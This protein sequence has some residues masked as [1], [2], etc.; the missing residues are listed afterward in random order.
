M[1]LIICEKKSLA[2][3]VAKALNCS[4]TNNNYF[5]NDEVYITW[6]FGHLFERV[7]GKGKWNITTLPIVQH[8]SD[9][10]IQYYNLKQDSGVKNQFKTI[11]MLANK[12]V[13]IINCCDPDTEGETIY[14]EV[15]ENLN[16]TKTQSR[17]W[18][19]DLTGTEL[20]NAY[21]NRQPLSNFNGIR[22]RGYGR[23]YFD[24]LYGINMTQLT[25]LIS[26]QTYHVGRV[27]TPT[28]KMIVDRYNE[29]KDFKQEIKY[30]PDL[31][32]ENTSIKLSTKDNDIFTDQDSV[33]NYLKQLG[34]LEITKS[35]V[36]KGNVKQPTLHDLG[37]IQ[38]WADTNLKISAKDT[39]EIVQKLYLNKLVSYPRTN[40]KYITQNT[41]EK[42]SK[43]LGRELIAGI[44]DVGNEHEALTPIAPYC[45]QLEGNEKAI[46]DEI[47]YTT[48]ANT[49]QPIKIDKL[50]INAYDESKNINWNKTI[51]KISEDNTNSFLDLDY[52][53]DYNIT[54]C[55][56]KETFEYLVDNPIKFTYEV[57]AYKTK[58]KPL[59]SES[60]LITKMENIHNDFDDKELTEISKETKGIGTPATRADIIN[61]LL[62]KKYINKQKN[63]LL[64]TQKGVDLIN[65]LEELKNPL[66]DIEYSAK[67]EQQ[68]A[69][70]QDNMNLEQ[71]M[72]SH[73]ALIN[74]YINKVLNTLEFKEC[75]CGGKLLLTEG[76]Y[77]EYFK[78]GDCGIQFANHNFTQEEID[79][80]FLG[81]QSNVKTL[82][83][84]SGNEYDCT[85]TIKD[86][87]LITNVLSEYEEPTVFC[88]CRC[89]GNITLRTGKFGEYF[90]CDACDIQFAN[91][92]FTEDDVI[93]MI[94]NQVSDIKQC[95][96]KDG[97]PYRAKFKLN[98][99]NKLEPIFVN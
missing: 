27:Q 49:Y 42:V 86:N 88:E 71:F 75:T 21:E 9:N 48:L 20:Q 25:S 4:T 19:K 32:I 78:C 84:Q 61:N 28:L 98:K 53:K 64:P 17:M 79:N 43:I 65:R 15:V 85:F 70:L 81:K 37:S 90:K 74:K 58:P 99:D 11:T 3:H 60:T 22:A 94:Y 67:L 36:L 24:A 14:R 46:Y 5:S 1:R 72:S 57:R 31:I 45:E 51:S 33:I 7:M 2:Q 8:P 59:F 93:K 41:A 91:H 29:N 87:K 12:S 39:L 56:D 89:G 44:G 63:K 68:L 76:I 54:N 69:D 95:V 16:I 10:Q 80:M 40:Q 92:N 52:F 62:E 55:V 18:F 77:G 13:E 47:Y 50:T 82:T 83:N 23:N 34:P 97:K 30:T 96:S 73:N 35:N 6:C 38:K 26:K 66:L